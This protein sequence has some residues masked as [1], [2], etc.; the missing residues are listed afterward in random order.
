MKISLGSLAPPKEN[1]KIRPCT[2]TCHAVR[3]GVPQGSVISLSAL[4]FYVSNYPSICN[5]QSSHADHSHATKS[6]RALS[7]HAEAVGHGQRKR[8]FKF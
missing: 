2:S 4:N 3:A 7:T 1:L 5:L 6:L 8:E